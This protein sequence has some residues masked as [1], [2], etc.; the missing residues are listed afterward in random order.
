[1][2]ISSIVS[3]SDLGEKATAHHH[4]SSGRISLWNIPS[5][6]ISVPM[7]EPTQMKWHC[8]VSRSVR[9]FSFCMWV[10]EGVNEACDII[11]I[12]WENGERTNHADRTVL[13]NPMLVIVTKVCH[14]L[15]TQVGLKN[16]TTKKRP[17]KLILSFE[18][19]ISPPRNDR[20][21]VVP[22]SWELSEYWAILRT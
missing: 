16:D 21:G 15:K 2:F 13:S 17:E 4:R 3:S 11:I 14:F 7:M 20:L 12:L 18:S 6:I 5:L 8:F 22:L 9:F 1:M 19:S 10:S